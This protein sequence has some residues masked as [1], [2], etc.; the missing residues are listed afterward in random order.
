MRR[1]HLTRQN[2]STF[3]T[4]WTHPVSLIVHFRYTQW[5]LDDAVKL[6]VREMDQQFGVIAVVLTV[7]KRTMED[8]N[9]VACCTVC[10][11][12]ERYVSHLQLIA[13]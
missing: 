13:T 3:F 1:K 6:F 4:T 8:G 7:Y 11:N 12:F 5:F 10:V 9:Q 2:R